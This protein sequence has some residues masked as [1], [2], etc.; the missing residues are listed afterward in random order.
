MRQ[1]LQSLTVFG[2]SPAPAFHFLVREFGLASS[3]L[4][5]YVPREH[6]CR[7]RSPLAAARMRESAASLMDAAI[8]TVATAGAAG[9]AAPPPYERMAATPPILCGDEKHIRW[10]LGRV[11]DNSA[12]RQALRKDENTCYVRKHERKNK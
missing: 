1:A 12:P 4:F 9:E 10:T 8:A 5:R 7:G 2:A 3:C 11:H 6:V